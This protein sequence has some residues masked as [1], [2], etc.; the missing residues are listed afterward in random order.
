MSNISSVGGYSSMMQGMQG[1]KR[2]D[3]KQMAEDLFSKLDTSGQGYLS[4]SDLETAF[5]KVS[6]SS[7]SSSSSN[8]DDLFSKLDSDGDGKVTKQE[9][10]DT[11]SKLADQLTNGAMQAGGGMPGMGMGGGMSGMGMPPPQGGSDGLT[12]DQLSSLADQTSGTSSGASSQVSDLLKN[13]DKADTNGDGKV[14]FTEAMAYQQSSDS[15]SSSTS[16]ASTSSSSDTSSATTGTS[17]ENSL[18]RMIMQLMQAYSVT[19]NGNNEASASTF[20]VTA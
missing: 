19:P 10:S 11:L 7:D 12:K 2:P 5:N 8:V 1:M 16:T 3:S 13:F 15:S 18:R 9:F 6:S 20:S 17:S 4:K 14:S